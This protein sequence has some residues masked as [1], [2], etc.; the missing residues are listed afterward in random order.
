MPPYQVRG[1]LLKSGMTEKSVYG[2]TLNNCGLQIADC[3]LIKEKKDF[4]FC[5]L[6]SE[7]RIPKSE[8]VLIPFLF[9]LGVY[10][11]WNPQGLASLPG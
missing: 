7:I 9:P 3:R 10:N 6:N 8:M 11:R 2:Q 4:I 1:R 5:L